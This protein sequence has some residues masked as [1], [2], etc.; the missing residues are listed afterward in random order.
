MPTQ[1]GQYPW[2]VS[3]TR[4]SVHVCAGVVV[5][6]RHVLTTA[7]CV[8]AAGARIEVTVPAYSLH[9][10]SAD[11]GRVGVAAAVPHPLHRGPRSHD[12][13]VVTLARRLVWSRGRV[14]PVC[15]G[16]RPAASLAAST[17]TP[18]YAGWGVTQFGQSAVPHYALLPLVD[19]ETCQVT[20][21]IFQGPSKNIWPDLAEP[22]RAPGP[23]HSVCWARAW[24]AGALSGEDRRL[25]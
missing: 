23:R 11:S 5:T 12:L 4:G 25:W 6:S 13:A 19:T 9:T 2:L 17:T 21:K 7:T 10:D 15:W 16:P 22:E 18:V 1:P 14:A 8:E 3:V 20:I 24:P